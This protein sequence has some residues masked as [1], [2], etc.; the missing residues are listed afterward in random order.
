[1]NDL[2]RLHKQHVEPASTTLALAFQD[3]PLLQYAFPDKAERQRMVSYYSQMVL[4]YGIRYGE[5]Y[6]TSPDFEGVAAWVTSAY[7]PMTFWRIIRSVPMSVIGAFSRGTGKEGSSRMKHAGNY[8]D[9]MHKRYAPFKHWFF[10][11]IGVAPQSQGK[12][13][14]STLIRPMLD[15]MDEEGL[16]CYIETMDERNVRLYGHF[17]FEVKE[18]FAIPDTRLTTWAMLRDAQGPAGDLKRG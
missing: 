14:A 10:L 4:Y 3:Y 2:V 6:S 18:K 9:A 12:G 5:V 7:F 16:P 17:G 1:M 11:I 15:R 13:Y 8:I